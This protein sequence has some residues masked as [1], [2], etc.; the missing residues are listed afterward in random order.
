VLRG[1]STGWQFDIQNNLRHD[2]F[3]L[4]SPR[5][6]HWAGFIAADG[7]IS[8]AKPQIEIQ[9]KTQDEPYLSQL[10]AWLNSL[11]PIRHT[12]DNR[13]KEPAYG[14]RL[15]ITSQQLVADLSAHYNITP[16]K[17]NTLQPPARKSVYFATGY[18]MGNGGLC[19][20]SR[21]TWCCYCMGS[22]EILTWIKQ[23]FADICDLNVR[24]YS[25]KCYRFD[26]GSQDNVALITKRIFKY[27]PYVIPRKLK[28]Y[29]SLLEDVGVRS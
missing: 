9:I 19:R 5:A 14:S 26:S 24:Q 7:W 25:R 6:D 2:A 1:E 18:W 10:Q 4:P 20:T 11:N 21:G 16:L 28:L 3:S 13:F 22:K 12:T 27:S 29:Q 8:R 15:T 17:S 23:F